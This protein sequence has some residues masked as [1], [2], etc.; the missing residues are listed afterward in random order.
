MLRNIANSWEDVQMDGEVLIIGGVQFSYTRKNKVEIEVKA[1]M[2]LLLRL[3]LFGHETVENDT[4]DSLMH[5]IALNQGKISGTTFGQTK[6]L[7]RI[8]SIFYV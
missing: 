3:Q 8:L 2:H 7:Q 5:E 4:T 1:A 6:N